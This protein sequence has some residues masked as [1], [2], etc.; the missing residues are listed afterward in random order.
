MCVFS[1]LEESESDSDGSED[2]DEMVADDDTNKTIKKHTPK[3]QRREA[4]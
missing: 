4:R 2:F 3:A 1:D